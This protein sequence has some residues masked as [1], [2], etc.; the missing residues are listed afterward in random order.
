[1]TDRDYESVSNFVRARF[2][3]VIEK[4]DRDQRQQVLKPV[5]VRLP[6]GSVALIDQIA[7]ELDLNR[8]E[9]LL[10]LIGEALLE[11][12]QTLANMAHE[13]KRAEVFRQYLDV[14][15]GNTSTEGGKHE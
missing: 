8:Q 14:L 15:T 12:A 7:T 4:E 1:M 11:A 13:A 10:N 5:S 3:E 9:F 6:E 2:I